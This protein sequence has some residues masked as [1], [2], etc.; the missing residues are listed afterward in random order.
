[1]V[2]DF[3]WRRRR[4]DVDLLLGRFD[5][6]YDAPS[7][8]AKSLVTAFRDQRIHLLMTLTVVAAALIVLRVFDPATSGIFPPC[9]LRALTGWYCPGCGSLRALHQLLH[10]NVENAFALNPLAVI[11]LPFLAYGMAS[12]ASFVIRGRYL[13]RVFLPAVWI[14]ALC[15]G[16]VAFGIMRNLPGYPFWVLAPGGALVLR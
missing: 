13:P 3:S 9:P 4:S 15:M 6:F 7:L 11:S 8:M 14:R 5:E 10:G 1:V 2:L 16:I 12:Y